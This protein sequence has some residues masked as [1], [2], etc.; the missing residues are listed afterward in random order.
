MRLRRLA[1][2]VAGGG[3]LLSLVASA[4]AAAPHSYAVTIQQM[5]F[6]PVP[7]VLHKGDTIT[8]INKDFLKH[9]ATAVNHSF[10]VDLPPNTKASMVVK[11]TGTIAFSCRYHP[12]MRG[13]LQVK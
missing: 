3:A 12:G 5:K 7:A 4:A 6:G 1:P 13:V 2:A 10:D 8:W 11:A 9:S